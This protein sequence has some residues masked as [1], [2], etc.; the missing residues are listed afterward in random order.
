MEYAVWYTMVT[1]CNPRGANT[2]VFFRWSEQFGS[3]VAVKRVT[4]EELYRDPK[5]DASMIKKFLRVN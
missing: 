5:F 2:E 3:P 4:K 1:L